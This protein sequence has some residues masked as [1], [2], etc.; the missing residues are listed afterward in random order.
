MDFWALGVLV[1]ELFTGQHPFSVKGGEVATYSRI[2]A[3]GTKAFPSLAYPDTSSISAAKVTSF[4]DKLV[5]SSPEA[6][7]GAGVGSSGFPALKKAAFFEGVNF[8][9]LAD[10]KSPMSPLA[11]AAHEIVAQEGLDQEIVAAF[12]APHDPA[13]WELDVDI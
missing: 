7:L 12:D 13:D 8:A 11:R 2:T 4:V 1:F 9:G 6:R 3:F 10:T 5:V